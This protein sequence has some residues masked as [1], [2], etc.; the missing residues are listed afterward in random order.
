MQ[1]LG[2]DGAPPPEPWYKLWVWPD[3][4]E[5][6]AAVS[7]A[8]N[9]AIGSAAIGV[10]TSVFGT[11]ATGP[12]AL[13]DG[14]FFLLAAIGIRQLSFPA[15]AMALLLYVVKQAASAQHGQSPGVIGLAL[16]LLLVGAVRAAWVALRMSAQERAQIANDSPVASWTERAFQQMGSPLWRKVRILFNIAMMLYFLLLLTGLV[17]LMAGLV[18]Q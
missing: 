3:V 2:L 5:P 7:A 9:G 16:S 14:A 10:L 8:R 18:P 12:A 11:M 15:S 17:V 6:E 13:F 4:T 1:T